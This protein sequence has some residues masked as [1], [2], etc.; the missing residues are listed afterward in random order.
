MLPEALAAEP[1]TV[2]V[3]G[4]ADGC[5]VGGAPQ[6]GELTIEVDPARIDEPAAGR[7][8]HVA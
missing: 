2:S 3:A 5:V 6:A 7:D 4:C 8:S 1:L